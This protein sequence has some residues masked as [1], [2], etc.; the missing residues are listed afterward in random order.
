MSRVVEILSASLRIVATSSTV[1]KAENSSGLWIHSATIRISTDSAIDAARP[2]SIITAGTGRKKRHRM[3][4][5]PT[6]KAMSLPPRFAAETGSAE[7]D[8]ALA[9]TTVAVGVDTPAMTRPRRSPMPPPAAHAGECAANLARRSN[10][11]GDH[12]SSGSFALVR[13]KFGM[14]VEWLG[15][16]PA[17]RRTDAE[18]R[19]FQRP[20]RRT[21]C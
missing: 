11:G 6:A 1:G 14:D 21:R 4:T 7:A 3:R 2:K 20:K 5:M 8:G 19:K 10:G 13:L 15:L 18:R 12:H 17:A 16:R 9:I